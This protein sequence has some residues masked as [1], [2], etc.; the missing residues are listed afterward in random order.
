MKAKRP[1]KLERGANARAKARAQQRVVSRLRAVAKRKLA[2]WSSKIGPGAKISPSH[3][4]GVLVGY[5]QALDDIKAADDK[6]TDSRR[7]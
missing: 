5:V 6:L 4:Y 7:E 1:S 3:K 2:Y